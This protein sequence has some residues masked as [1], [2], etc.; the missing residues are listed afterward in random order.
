MLER[1]FEIL[2]R[3]AS[4][5]FLPKGWTL[6]AQQLSLSTGRL[7]MLFTDTNSNSHVI[8]LKKGSAPKSSVD[9]VLEYTK[10]ISLKYPSKKFI[11][12]VIAHKI[13]SATENHANDNRV[14]TLAISIDKCFEVMKKRNITVKD[15]AGR[16]LSKKILHG[17][18]SGIKPE[19]QIHNREVFRE[20]SEDVAEILRDINKIEHIDMTSGSM[21]TLIHYKGVKLGGYNRKHRGRHGYI[22][23]GVVLS[24]E[25]SNKLKALNFIRMTKT[26]QGS[27]HMHVW[28]EIKESDMKFYS[29]A[30]RLCITIVESAL[31]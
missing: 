25:T 1:E 5:E 7:D 31:D 10:D 6:K 29:E 28:W 22:T 13:S 18:G 30:I 11:P 26:Q 14:K 3:T 21:Q 16:R 27:S 8:E 20:I 15:L 17:G 9:Q 12:W 23:D 2:L 19:K 4:E 24:E